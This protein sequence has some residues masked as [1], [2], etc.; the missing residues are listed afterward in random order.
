MTQ[1]LISGF[2]GANVTCY[3]GMNTSFLTY[4]S[5]KTVQNLSKSFE[6]VQFY[7]PNDPK[8]SDRKVWANSANSDQTTPKG[9]KP[10]LKEQSDQGLHCLLFHLNH[11]DKI[12]LG[13]VSLFE[14]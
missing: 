10:L 9:A 13:L 6:G 1:R 5:G 14:F 4:G 3:L 8:F 11:F 12:L 2:A 7:Y